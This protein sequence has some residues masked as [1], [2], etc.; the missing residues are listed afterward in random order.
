MT[1]TVWGVLSP[2]G[3]FTVAP[4]GY[5]QARK[6][7]DFNYHGHVGDIGEVIATQDSL[8]APIDPPVCELR[9]KPLGMFSRA[10]KMVADEGRLSRI[11]K[12][13]V[14]F[15]RFEGSYAEVSAEAVRR[16]NF[17]EK[18]GFLDYLYYAEVIPSKPYADEDVADLSEELTKEQAA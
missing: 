16:N 15:R 6:W 8:T 17:Q 12:V 18:S 10:G 5:D 9:V 13:P 3:T 1:E 4:R 7:A 14:A 11:P 2:S